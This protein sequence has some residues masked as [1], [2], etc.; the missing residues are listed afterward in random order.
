VGQRR[1]PVSP[2][3]PAHPGR[4]DELLSAVEARNPERAA[5]LWHKRMHTAV[6]EFLEL[7]PDGEAIEQKRPWL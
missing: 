6:R 4:H 1:F 3:V 2:G 5:H 7:V